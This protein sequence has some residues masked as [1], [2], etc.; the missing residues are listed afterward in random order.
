MEIYRLNVLKINLLHQ[1]PQNVL[2]SLGFLSIRETPESTPGCQKASQILWR[3]GQHCVFRDSHS[4]RKNTRI[5]DRIQMTWLKD[6]R[7]LSELLCA[8]NR[9]PGQLRGG[10]CS[11]TG[12]RDADYSIKWLLTSAVTARVVRGQADRVSGCGGPN[13]GASEPPAPRR[14]RP[15]NARRRG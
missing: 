11:R 8:I 2:T 4:G 1:W 15:T 9:L 5:Y 12:V 3:C 6:V 14:S 10:N 13:V 7:T